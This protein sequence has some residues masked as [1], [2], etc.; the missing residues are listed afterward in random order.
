MQLLPLLVWRMGILVFHVFFLSRFP[1]ASKKTFNL[2]RIVSDQVPKREKP[3]KDEERK[4]EMRLLGI[5]INAWQYFFTTLST[6]D[7][8]FNSA[9]LL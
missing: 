3:K 6:P 8:L 5:V 4:E 2:H 1:M 7:Y 9:M